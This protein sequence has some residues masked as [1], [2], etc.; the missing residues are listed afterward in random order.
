MNYLDIANSSTMFLL[1]LIPAVTIVAVAVLFIRT[2]WKRGIELGM[3]SDKL[4][5]CVR[6]SI[7]FS[8]VPTLS[9]L[10]LM[11][12]LAPAIG[13]F[14]PWMR[15]INIGAGHYEAIA[16]NIGMQAAGASEWS[17][18][19]LGGY[20]LVMLVM[21]FGMCVAPLLCIFTIKKFDSTLKVAKGSKPFMNIATTALYA[22]F[23]AF[24]TMPYAVNT[25]KPLAM[26]ALLIGGGVRFVC[27]KLKK[28][29]PALQEF[30]MTLSLLLA[31]VICIIL[32]QTG[33]FA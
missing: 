25:K 17:E 1:C 3:S 7:S 33:I 12:G 11:V 31:M 9:L 29:Y 8:I 27:I 14:Y 15:M 10:I 20:V 26:I 16:A 4:K 21:N 24:S 13:K 5:K 23:I 18:L 30:S 32:A 28:K 2:A 22:G 6:S 19:T